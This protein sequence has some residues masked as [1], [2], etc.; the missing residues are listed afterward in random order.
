MITWFSFFSQLLMM[1]ET[2][3]EC[4]V[5]SNCTTLSV[6]LLEA[7]AC[8]HS[9][10][11]GFTAHSEWALTLINDCSTPQVVFPLFRCFLACPLHGPIPA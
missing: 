2:C 3:P 4:L 11:W 1:T 6:D 10:G 7:E 8:V 5:H 9:C